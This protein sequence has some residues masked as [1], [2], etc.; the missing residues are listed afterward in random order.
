VNIADEMNRSRMLRLLVFKGVRALVPILEEA[1]FDLG[2]RFS[3]IC[4]LCFEIFSKPEHALVVRKYF[5]DIE[6]QAIHRS[7]EYFAELA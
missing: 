4:H 1:G 5:D 6:Q 2:D 3:N 7:L